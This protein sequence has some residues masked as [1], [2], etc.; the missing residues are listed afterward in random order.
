[1]KK[2]AW[3]AFLAVFN[4]VWMMLGIHW[5]GDG[6]FTGIEF[7]QTALVLVNFVLTAHYS[8]LVERTWKAYRQGKTQP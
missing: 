4:L 3:Y 8:V 2:I 6:V 7:L 5:L 1:M